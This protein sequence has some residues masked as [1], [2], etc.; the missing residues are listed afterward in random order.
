MLGWLCTPTH[1]TQPSDPSAELWVVLRA[2][3]TLCHPRGHPS[4]ATLTAPWKP[5]QSTQPEPFGLVCPLVLLSALI[6]QLLFLQI[7]TT[8]TW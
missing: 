3:S 7:T 6:C 2:F 5:T 8:T 4:L 1:L